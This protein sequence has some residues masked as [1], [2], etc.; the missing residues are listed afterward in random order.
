MLTPD[1][2]LVARAL[3]RKLPS[4]RRELLVL[5]AERREGAGADEGL[6]RDLVGRGAVSTALAQEVRA[7]VER[8]KRGR[9]LGLFVHLLTAQG[10]DRARLEEE[11]R[12]LG[13]DARAVD[14]GRAAVARGLL[15]ESVCRQLLFQARVLFDRD[16]RRQLEE[17]LRAA[18]PTPRNGP[19]A[20]GVD[21]ER[22]DF[23]ARLP[24]M[25][26]EVFRGDA[27]VPVPPEEA[28]EIL[29]SSS[30]EGFTGLLKPP[31]FPVPE[32][33]DTSVLVGAPLLVEDH[34]LLGRIEEGPAATVYL[35]H[36]LHDHA[37][38]RALK[39]LSADASPI[40]R[41]RLEREAE[42]AARVH[43]PL[44]LTVH[45]RGVEDGRPFLLTEFFD[46]P[47]L[48]RLLDE[49]GCLDWPQ[50]RLLAEGLLGVL[51]ALHS[52]G[53]V[54]CTLDARAVLVVPDLGDLRLTNLGAARGPGLPHPAPPLPRSAAVAPE[55]L[56]GSL[57]T[58]SADLY[59][60]GILLCEA[61][62]GSADAPASSAQRRLDALPP[63]LPSDLP[64]LL[65]RLIA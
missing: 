32:W 37:S 41:A 42:V 3:S 1:D 65:A 48:G 28:E 59:S 5:L 25:G 31:S 10:I 14:L 45:G 47:C 20:V 44:L 40:A 43:H 36:A 53:L 21:S 27:I 6:L 2:L 55:L 15:G 61:L 62:G 4:L 49:R 18:E 19:G 17:H 51:D 11:Y 7:A 16:L 22:F 35:A 54:H 23:F 56:A 8:H 34:R 33:I 46:G 9:A 13:G 29:E 57:P 50:A 64:P 39:I 30:Q 26:S 63:S 38:P 58:P 24:A 12:A 60:L 52:A